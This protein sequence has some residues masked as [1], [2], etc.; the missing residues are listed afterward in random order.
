MEK[1]STLAYLPC[2]LSASKLSH[3]PRRQLVAGGHIW[4]VT[5]DLGEQVLPSSLLHLVASVLGSRGGIGA[6]AVSAVAALLVG[7]YTKSTVWQTA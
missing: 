4:C 1:H 5:L 7:V 3:A 6:R 2:A